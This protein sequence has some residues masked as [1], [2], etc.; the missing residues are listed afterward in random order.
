MAAPDSILVKEAT[1]ILD[2]AEVATPSQVAAS[3]ATLSMRSTTTWSVAQQ[4]SALFGMISTQRKVS[5]GRLGY[6]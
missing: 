3:G 5:E 1:P 4:G 2:I 6:F